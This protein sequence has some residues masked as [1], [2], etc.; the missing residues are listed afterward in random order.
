MKIANFTDYELIECG[1]GKKFERWKNVYLCR[2]DP[3]AI[4]PTNLKNIDDYKKLNAIYERSNLGGGAWNIVKPFN[5]EW[6]VEDTTL[7]LKFVVK[8]MGFKHTGLFP[9]QSV[10]WQILMEM[11]QHN[12]SKNRE[13]K[14]LNLFGYTGGATVACLKAG[15]SVTHVDASKGMVDRCKQNVNLNGLGDKKVRYIVDDCEK[16]VEREIRRGNFYDIIIMDPPSFGRGPNGETWKLENNIFSLVTKCSKLLTPS[17]LAFLIN[18]YTTGLQAVVME[19]ILKLVLKNFK[20]EFT[21]YELGL[22][23]THSNIVLPCGTSALFY[24]KTTKKI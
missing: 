6:I 17:P 15:A 5:N 1:D 2:P 8:P 20:G 22:K 14:V 11:I 7:N 19:N 23:T 4:W 18:S 16:F 13:I 10:N 21:S 3:Q 12:I 9:E 24:T